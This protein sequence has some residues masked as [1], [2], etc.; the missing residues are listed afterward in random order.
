MPPN[1]ALIDAPMPQGGTT[2]FDTLLAPSKAGLRDRALTWAGPAFSAVVLAA[3]F[4]QINLSELRAILGGVPGLSIFWPVFALFYLTVPAAEWIIYRRVWRLPA[5][6]IAPLLRKQVANELVLGYSGEAQF[7][8][9][10]RRHAGVSGS[11]FGAIKDVTVLSAMVGNLAALAMM[12]AM[13]PVLATLLVGPLAR[14]F[15]ISI[16]VVVLS[17][18][19]PFLFRRQLFSLPRRDLQFIGL[20][21]LTRIGLVLTFLIGLWHLLLPTVAIG[22]WLGL[23]TLRMMLGRLPLLPNKDILFAGATMLLL[24][25]SADISAMLALVASIG[26]AAHVLVGIATG[27]AALADR[28]TS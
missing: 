19:I 17:S 6:G 22:H 25:R 26:L 20:V 16:A 8:L 27:I 21:H 9:W 11:P 2:T 24:G 5:G 23:A 12:L 13:M 7:Y 28:S 18:L 3:I 4:T 10:A 1:L 15:A 14:S